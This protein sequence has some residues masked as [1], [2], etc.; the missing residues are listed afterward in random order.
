MKL[1][2]AGTPE[3]AARILADLLPAG[4]TLA[5]VYTQPDRPAGRGRKVA[6]SAVKRLAL[7]HGLPVHQP[8][9][10]KGPEQEGILRDLDVDAL[11]VAAYG[12]ILPRSLLDV[13]THGCINV[14]A[15]LLPRWRGA[16]PIQRAI[17]AGDRTTGVSIMRMD[18]GLDTGPVFVTR[19]TGIG[20][21]DTAAI[22]HDRLAALGSEAL[23]QVLGDLPSGT[24]TPRPQTESGATYAARLEKSEARLDWSLDAAE[25]DR[26]VRAFN[27]VPMAWT[28]LRLPEGSTEAHLRLRVLMTRPA[29]PSG[30]AG[31]PGEVLRATGEELRVACGN[32]EIILEQVQPAGRK[33]MSAAQF[34]TS[35]SLKPGVLLE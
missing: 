9:T 26:Q 4:H 10:L 32:G 35:R 7:E 12:L 25:L 31:S 6:P 13:T 30:S 11:V 17:L 8:A 23:L 33:P 20:P 5:A 21:R 29:A 2:F 22:L 34:V 28:R 24:L 1:A 27:P 18:A 3:F 15:S 16:A 14:H 19:E